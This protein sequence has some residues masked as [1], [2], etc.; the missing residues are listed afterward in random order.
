MHLQ[1]A[2]VGIGGLAQDLQMLARQIVIVRLRVVVQV[3]DH[4]TRAHEACVEIHVRIGDVFA[5]DAGQPDHLAQAQV[6][7]QFRFDIRA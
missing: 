3:G 4:H 7:L 6:V 5:S 1:P 2:T